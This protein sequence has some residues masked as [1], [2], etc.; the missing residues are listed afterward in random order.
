MK[1]IS[2]TLFFPHGPEVVWQYLT[3]ADLMELWLMKSDFLPV[4]GHQFQFRIPPM[5]QL[6]FDGVIHCKVLDIVPMKKLSYTWN[7]GPGDGKFTLDSVVEW[8]LHPKDNGTELQLQHTGFK[9]TEHINMF[10]ALE[11]GWLQNMNKILKLANT[12]THGTT[13]A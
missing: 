6:E 2:H 13:T 10:A 7:S 3:N 8:T 1:K 9:G 12:A 4:A 5:P 11:G